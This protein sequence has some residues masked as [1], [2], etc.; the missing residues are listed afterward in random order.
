MIVCSGTANGCKI[1]IELANKVAI[2][3]AGD[4]FN[5]KREALEIRGA[6]F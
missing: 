6:E 3:V 1:V 5:R 2:V 4:K